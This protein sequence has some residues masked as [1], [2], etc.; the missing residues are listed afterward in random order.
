MSDQVTVQVSTENDDHFVKVDEDAFKAV[1]SRLQG[2]ER[3]TAGPDLL[4][5]MR[6]DF[7]KLA[8]STTVSRT[9]ECDYELVLD[10]TEDEESW[11]DLLDAWLAELDG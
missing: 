6:Q 5:Q 4:T 1:A 3:G 8:S 10:G 9:S 2:V 11:G 7:W